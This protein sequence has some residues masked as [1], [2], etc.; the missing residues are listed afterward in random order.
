[1][2][3]TIACRTAEALK[4]GRDPSRP[5]G[6]PACLPAARHPSKF[7]CW[8]RWRRFPGLCPPPPPPPPLGSA[9]RP[10]L[11]LIG[12]VLRGS[13]KV[14]YATPGCN[15]PG[16][17]DRCSKPKAARIHPCTH[18]R[19]EGRTLPRPPAG[20]DGGGLP[21]QTLSLLRATI[22]YAGPQSLLTN[23]SARP[24]Q[25]SAH[26][27]LVLLLALMDVALRSSS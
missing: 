2:V 8:S 12:V 20:A 26:L 21:T 4:K 10:P 16:L 23:T 3:L 24:R 17:A 1:V 9:L 18:W 14:V 11:R 5:A 27:C 15:N 6:R 25:P 19:A 13:S 22:F 7:S